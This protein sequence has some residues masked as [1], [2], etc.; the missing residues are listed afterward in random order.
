MKKLTKQ[1]AIFVFCAFLVAILDQFIKYLIIYYSQFSN[2]IF[3]TR[4]IDIVL[5]FNEGAAFSIGSFFGSWLKWIILVM[6]FLMIYLII[7]NKDLYS[8]FYCHFGFIIGSGFSNLIDRFN[9]VGVVDYIYW[10]YGFKFAIFN[11]ADVVINLSIF[12]V[13]YNYIRAQISKKA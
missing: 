8:K 12:L 1:N 9:Y 5:V 6:L 4:F 13:V 7:S 2:P 3:E 11:M 10:H